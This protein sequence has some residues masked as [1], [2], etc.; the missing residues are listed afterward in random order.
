MRVTFPSKNVVKGAFC[1]NCRVHSDFFVLSDIQANEQW[2]KTHLFLVQTHLYT[3]LVGGGDRSQLP[4][5]QVCHQVA[6]RSVTKSIGV[7]LAISPR[8]LG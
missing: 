8:P 2:S 5:L 6:P 3:S 7:T 4:C 1:Y